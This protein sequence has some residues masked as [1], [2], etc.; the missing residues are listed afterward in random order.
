MLHFPL[1]WSRDHSCGC[2]DRVTCF[3]LTY[4]NSLPPSLRPSVRPS[5]RP[6]LR[7]SGFRFEAGF[8]IQGIPSGVGA[9]FPTPGPFSNPTAPV[10]GAGVPHSRTF[11]PPFRMTLHTRLS[12]HGRHAVI[13]GKTRFWAYNRS[14]PHERAVTYQPPRSLRYPRVHGPSIAF[15]FGE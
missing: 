13:H 3:A 2:R 14:V 10:W 4:S 15:A 6:S 9:H 11:P 1:R 12:P 5:L 7:P 8:L